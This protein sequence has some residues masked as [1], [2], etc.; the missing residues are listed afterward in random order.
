MARKISLVQCWLK[1]AEEELAAP[2]T[3]LARQLVQYFKKIRVNVRALYLFGSQARQEAT[4]D[5]DIDILVVSP[6]FNGLDL[7][8]R[9][10]RLGFVAGSFTE[11]LQFYP[12][13]PREFRYPEPGGFIQAIRPDLKLLYP[14]PQRSSAIKSKGRIGSGERRARG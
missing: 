12:V 11:P 7:W 2:H 14:R 13:T 10:N 9:Y 1:S 5:S 4:P 6:T 3:L 8:T